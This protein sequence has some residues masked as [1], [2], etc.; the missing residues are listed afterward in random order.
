[1]SRTLKFSLVMLLAIPIFNVCPL[2]LAG[3]PT[4]PAPTPIIA[5]TT[6]RN[7]LEVDVNKV[8]CQTEFS[9]AIVVSG[10]GTHYRYKVGPSGTTNPSVLTGYSALIPKATPVTFNLTGQADGGYVLC[11]QGLELDSRGRIKTSQP[12]SQAT[13]YYWTKDTAPVEYHVTFL[14]K[15][16]N[17]TATSP[18]QIWAINS[19]G[20]AVG[21]C[22][23]SDGTGYHAIRWTVE[24]G[25]EDISSLDAPWFDLESEAIVDGWIFRSA[26][27]INE[28]GQIA[29][30]GWDGVAKRAVVYDPVTGFTLLPKPPA[31]FDQGDYGLYAINENGEVQGRCYDLSGY[32]KTFLW[33]PVN[34]DT[35]H[36]IEPALTT[37]F[38]SEGGI[39]TNTF[40][41]S[42]F[43][44]SGENRVFSLYTFAFVNGAL[45]YEPLDTVSVYPST[46]S[47]INTLINNNGAFGY[48]TSG[49]TTKYFKLYQPSHGSLTVRESTAS[50]DY[51]DL[52][53][54]INNSND[55]VYN[56]D[57][58][59]Y[60]YRYGEN[61]SYRLYDLADSYT[62]SAL[63]VSS[64]GI[65]KNSTRGI[66]NA[67]VSD[68]DAA[69][70]ANPFD[71]ISGYVEYDLTTGANE[72][73]VLTPVAK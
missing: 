21:R 30:F 31:S 39:G 44:G 38:T 71:T 41:T 59:P 24:S 18:A 27:D 67:V 37:T 65:L 42:T 64:A 28:A 6:D 5:T 36:V 8:S 49:P 73:F 47:G 23:V 11:L 55:F 63:F 19:S 29:G 1:M 10:T 40:M 58:V 4:P 57:D 12:L 61:R 50:R 68:D 16:P 54:R 2:A 32:S 66:V 26:F 69:P 20:T 48:C 72:G 56:P 22:Y 33:T 60:L 70:V 53:L 3:K 46:G 35:I 9:L 7:F 43:V 45:E 13:A 14:P 52:G 17:Q 62:K 25:L 34:P 51:A 15:L